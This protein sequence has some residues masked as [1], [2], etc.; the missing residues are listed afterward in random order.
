MVQPAEFTDTQWSDL[1][2]TVLAFWWPWIT[3]NNFECSCH[4][5][6]SYRHFGDRHNKKT[7]FDSKW[8]RTGFCSWICV[9]TVY[10]TMG[11]S[12][13][14]WDW[15][16]NLRGLSSKHRE[17]GVD[18]MQQSW[19][20]FCGLVNGKQPDGYDIWVAWHPAKYWALGPRPRLPLPS[21]TDH[22]SLHLQPVTW[23]HRQASADSSFRHRQVALRLLT[24]FAWCWNAMPRSLSNWRLTFT[25]FLLQAVPCPPLGTWL[26]NT[27][28]RIAVS[29][30]LDSN[31]CAPHTCICGTLVNSIGTHGF[32]LLQVCWPPHTSHRLSTIW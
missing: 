2:V 13:K 31:M 1:I 10:W 6:V 12:S 21:S 24:L 14:T 7:V 18:A 15:D 22:R 25:F 4:I 29:L 32:S 19:I 27:L 26:H 17:V 16:F 8:K 3:F 9:K 20:Y 5:F 28:L 11:P 23:Q 30:H